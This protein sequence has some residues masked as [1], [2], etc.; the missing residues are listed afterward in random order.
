MATTYQ[1]KCTCPSAATGTYP[2]CVCTGDL[3]YN[4]ST[5]TCECNG[6]NWCYAGSGVC[7][8]GANGCP[9]LDQ[10]EYARLT[11]TCT[12]VPPGWISIEN[13]IFIVLFLIGLIVLG[14]LLNQ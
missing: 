13:V 9:T 2:N 5:N 14:F 11:G 3:T 4:A 8:N 6:T 12:Q 1:S 10:S 7:T